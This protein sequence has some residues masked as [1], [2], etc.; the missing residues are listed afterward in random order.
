ME[1][2]AEE[3]ELKR[4]LGELTIEEFSRRA[5]FFRAQRFQKLSVQT[6][7][8]LLEQVFFISTP[9]RAEPWVASFV[10]RAKYEKDTRFFRVRRVAHTNLEKPEEITFP[11]PEMD[12]WNDAW[13][14]PAEVC[15]LGRLN[16]EG[17]SALYISAI[18]PVTAID[19]C[20]ILPGEK[21][22]LIIYKAREPIVANCVG[23]AISDVYNFLSEREKRV[24]DEITHFINAEFTR[25]VGVGTE[26]LYKISHALLE[27][28]YDPSKVGD[29]PLVYPSVTNKGTSNLCFRDPKMGQS[30]LSLVTSIVMYC[31]ESGYA[32]GC[33]ATGPR[34]D[35]TL[36]WNHFQSE[37]HKI[38]VLPEFWN[39]VTNQDINA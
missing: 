34:G 28:R 37:E 14:P 22:A 39:K 21:F 20:K 24:L 5:A 31:S 25:D 15:P 26:Y 29:N 10:Q 19:E 6:I 17:Q 13:H 35:G 4:Y 23:Y 1:L 36:I 2:S 30:Q 38:E 33:Y 8:R 9:D 11:V 7:R 32:H 12:H 16:I 27:Q 18:N 3:A